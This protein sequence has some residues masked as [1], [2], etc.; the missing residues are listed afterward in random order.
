M[1]WGSSSGT[2][3][4]KKEQRVPGVVKERENLGRKAVLLLDSTED[5]W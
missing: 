5:M 1:G 2:D 4:F 3:S